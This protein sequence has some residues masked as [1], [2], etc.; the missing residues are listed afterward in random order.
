MDGVEDAEEL[1]R[2]GGRGQVEFLDL[3]AVGLAGGVLGEPAAGGVV[4]E[5]EAALVVGVA[6]QIAHGN[7]REQGLAAV[8]FTEGEGRETGCLT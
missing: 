7:K 8:G 4:V 2:G 3:K 1:V 5:G 6:L